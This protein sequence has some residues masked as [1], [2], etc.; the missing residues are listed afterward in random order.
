MKN[1]SNLIS[2]KKGCIHF[3][4]QTPPSLQEG[5]GPQKQFFAIFSKTTGGSWGGG[6]LNNKIFST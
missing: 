6:L 4:H 5:L 2:H 1:Y 3:R